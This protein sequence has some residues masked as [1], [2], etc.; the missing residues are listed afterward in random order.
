MSSDDTIIDTQIKSRVKKTKL[1]NPARWAQVIVDIVHSIIIIVIWLFPNKDDK[2]RFQTSLI[3][4]GLYIL[5]MVVMNYNLTKEES[6]T[7]MPP[8]NEEGLAHLWKSFLATFNTILP[9]IIILV[10]LQIF[11][12]W[13]LPFSNT[14]G[15]AIV[16][17]KYPN[18]LDSL[19][20]DINTESNNLTN[21][22]GKSM[23]S[24]LKHHG[25]KNMF[26][27]NLPSN[28][29][30]M[31]ET[32]KEIQKSMNIFKL[33]LIDVNG[34]PT[35]TGNIEIKKLLGAVRYKFGI[36]R[37]IWFASILIICAKM[38]ELNLYNL[39]GSE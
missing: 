8:N 9:L 37:I 35:K 18:L 12:G 31:K 24:K 19:L 14:I 16:K 27:N 22:V 6:I 7:I 2:V 33:D 26:I 10:M 36:S 15:Y 39:V 4:I 17:K 11:P 30:K 21:P 5:V 3:V 23:I 28:E 32:L 1:E 38:N 13:L 20:V 29:D 34:N 25:Y